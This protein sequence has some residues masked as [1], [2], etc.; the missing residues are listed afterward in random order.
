MNTRP[1]TANA[2]AA[3]VKQAIFE[4]EDIRDAAGFDFDEVEHNLGFV[5]VL[6]KELRALR[7]AMADG[8]Y[9]FD[10]FDLPMMRVVKKYTEKELPCIKL[11]YLINE[12]HLQGLD[13]DGG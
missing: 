12:T 4:L 6:L 1:K 8:S 5:E 11:L 3:L 2:Y 7:A 9:R 10:R 13:I